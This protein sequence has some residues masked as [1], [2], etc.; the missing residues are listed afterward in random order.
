MYDFSSMKKLLDELANGYVPAM[1]MCV[2]KDH[3]EIFRYQAGYGDVESKQPLSPESN[4]FLFSCTKPITCTSALQLYEKGK[5]KLTDPLYEYIPEFAD[6]VVEEKDEDGGVRYVKPNRHIIIK[7]L[8]TMSA[9][10]S[11]D[12]EM[13]P[14]KEVIKETNGI[15]PTRK[16]V[17]AIAKKPLLF[18]PGE[19]YNYSL[20]HDVLGGVIEVISGRSLGEYMKENIFDPCGMTHTGFDVTPEIKAA[21]PTL[22]TV[23]G[24]NQF[25]RTENNNP[26]I[27]GD[28]SEYESG[29]AGLVSCTADYIKFADAMA[30]MGVSALGERILNEETVELM[31]YPHVTDKFEHYMFKQWGYDYGLGVRTMQHP[32]ISGSSVSV[33]EFGWDGAA[34]SYVLIDPKHKLSMFCAQFKYGEG[35]NA[36]VRFVHKLYEIIS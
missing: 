31:R 19:N 17:G 14:L 6:V 1:D 30:H 20:C 32:K 8:F 22:Y 25:E 2:Y 11:Y 23:R 36:P 28:D 5:L 3:E 10:L 12:L 21:M 29:G 27:Y 26:F 4:Y 34:G 7:D 15:C 33:G 13:A 24:V 35:F 18:H 9:G 16:M